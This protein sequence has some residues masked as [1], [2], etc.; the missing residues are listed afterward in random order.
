L[1]W[2]CLHKMHAD[3]RKKEFSPTSQTANWCKPLCFLQ[4]SKA[5]IFCKRS[6]L[7]FWQVIQIPI[8]GSKN[9]TKQQERKEGCQRDLLIDCTDKIKNQ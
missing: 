7:I 1:L 4:S 2:R 3:Q 5:L 9:K 8:L 6:E